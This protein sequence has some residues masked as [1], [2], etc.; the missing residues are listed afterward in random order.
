MVE[1]GHGMV[2]VPII[3]GHGELSAI[4][5]LI[6]RWTIECQRQYTEVSRPVRAP[7]RGGLVAVGGIERLVLLARKKPGCSRILAVVDAH[8]ALPC[9]EG[10]QLLARAEECA[11]TVPVAVVEAK[12]EYEAWII[13][14]A[15]TVRGVRG[16]PENLE[17][18]GD[19]DGIDDARGWLS[20]QMPAG[21]VY[22]PTLDQAALTEHINFALARSRSPSFDKL[23]RSLEALVPG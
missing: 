6:R 21:R 17:C 3:E 12:C 23:I 22:R 18:P 1:P 11:G 9:V 7:G 10:P 4:P 14:S 8:E 5:N 19:P 2:L 16:L 20:G 15:E 13:A